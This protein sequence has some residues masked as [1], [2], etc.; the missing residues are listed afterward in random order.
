MIR[1]L[2]FKLG[3]LAAAIL[4]GSRG[5]WG[6]AMAAEIATIDGD[7]DAARFAAGCF[8][9]GLK[10]RAADFDTRFAA[11]LWSLATASA[12]FA[13]FHIR[14]AW[15]GARALLGGPDAFY[16]TLWRNDPTVA[17]AYRGAIPMVA[18]CFLLLGL[19]HLCG[20]YLLARRRF[21]AFALSWC[22]ALAIATFVV[23][24]ELSVVWTL[25]GVPSEFF[26]LILQSLGVPALLL[27]KERTR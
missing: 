2:A 25:D 8:I 21:R 20:A 7:W 27:W 16:E 24:I 5:A 19:V 18:S 1:R 15:G 9:A 10:E 14:N 3:G 13:A 6:E 23:A 22:A 11:G 26:A 4:P 17:A 12:A